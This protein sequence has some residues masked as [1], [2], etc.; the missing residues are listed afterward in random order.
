V[1]GGV[2]WRSKNTRIPRG[3]WSGFS[4][5]AQHFQQLTHAIALPSGLLDFF[6]R[7]GFQNLLVENTFKLAT[8]KR[9]AS[10]RAIRVNPAAIPVMSRAWLKKLQLPIAPLRLKPLRRHGA[11]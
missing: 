8:C 4:V 1:R 7:G 5:V 2:E 3:Q 9:P 6:H 10:L 11:K